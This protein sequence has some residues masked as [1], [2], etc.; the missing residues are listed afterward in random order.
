MNGT[1][2]PC[3]FSAAEDAQRAYLKAIRVQVVS[4]GSIQENMLIDV[5]LTLIVRN[6]GKRQYSVYCC[7]EDEDG[8][9]VSTG[10]LN[11]ASPEQPV[12]MCIA[13]AHLFSSKAAGQPYIYHAVAV[14]RDAR[15]N[16]LHR[17]EQEFSLLHL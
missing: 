8:I 14:L 1:D 15:F 7:I 2:C 11:L 4:S 5:Q 13:Q 6:M 3:I 17:F 16:M 9:P 10:R 12:R